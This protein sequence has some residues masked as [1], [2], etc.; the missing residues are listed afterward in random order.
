MTKK[1]TQEDKK[2]PELTSFIENVNKK[3]GRNGL[4]IHFAFVNRKRKG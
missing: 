1:T 3:D 4:K 2:D